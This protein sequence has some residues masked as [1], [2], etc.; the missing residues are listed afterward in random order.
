[1]AEAADQLNI[2]ALSK[3]VTRH[4]ICYPKEVREG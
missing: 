4:F 3:S 1:M 2:Q